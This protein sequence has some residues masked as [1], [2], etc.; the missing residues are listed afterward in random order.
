MRDGASTMNIHSRR[1]TQNTC[2]EKGDDQDL[3]LSS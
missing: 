1:M 3:G 2:E